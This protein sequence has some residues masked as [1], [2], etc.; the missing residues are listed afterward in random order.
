MTFTRKV[1]GMYIKD[2]FGILV[3]N[4][5]DIISFLAL[6]YVRDKARGDN[7]GSVQIVWNTQKTLEM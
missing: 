4:T 5:E 1:E 6:L 2:I 3:V 7:S